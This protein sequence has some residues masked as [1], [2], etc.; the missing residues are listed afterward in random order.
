[1][2]SLYPFHTGPNT[3]YFP[4]RLRFHPLILLEGF[5]RPLYP[6]HDAI[7]PLDGKVQSSPVRLTTQSY[8]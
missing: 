1:L 5:S 7:D 8:S 4:L 6:V 2:A 3:I